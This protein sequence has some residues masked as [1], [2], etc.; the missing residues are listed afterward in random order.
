VTLG[1]AFGK[2]RQTLKVDVTT[3]D[4]VTPRAIE[5]S[6]GLM[7]EDRA[8]RIMAYNTETVLAEKLEAVLTRG[9]ANTRMRDFYDVHILTVTQKFDAE[10]FRAA[11]ANTTER[12]GTV[13]QTSAPNA[14]I[15]T[16]AAD[17]DMTAFWQRY[18]KKNSYAANVSWETA[19]EA[20]R[21]LA[22]LL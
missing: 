4:L 9:V 7:F 21:A 14:V 15:E 8:I 11:F 6:Y 16:V 2:T 19:M 1:A 22:S 5:Y 18:Q 3:G 20:L 17:A 12:R 13:R 10:T